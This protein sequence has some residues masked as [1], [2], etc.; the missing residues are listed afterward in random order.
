M[1]HKLSWGSMYKEPSYGIKLMMPLPLF[2]IERATIYYSKVFV[3]DVETEVVVVFE[4][5][6]RVTGGISYIVIPL[7]SK[8]LV[9]LY[10]A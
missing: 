3:V 7:V 1:S 4:V 6:V 9:S 2:I 5:L 10:I 8:P